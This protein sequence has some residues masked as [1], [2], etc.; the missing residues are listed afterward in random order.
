VTGWIREY[1]GYEPADERLRESLCTLGN[2]YFATRG[3][4]PEC[5]ADGVHYPGTYVA[6]CYNRLTSDVAGHQV[7]NEDMVNAPNWLP[8]NF[9]LPG[10]PW[11][12]PDTATVLEHHMSLHLAAGMSERRTR[13]DLGEGQALTVRQ[14]R[15]V[16]MADPHLAASRTEFTAEGSTGGL[17]VE[18]AL[19]GG[20]TNSG[21]ERYRDLDGRHLTHVRTGTA[22]PDTVWLRCRTRTSDIRIG[23]AARLHAGTDITVRADVPRVAQL[24]RLK[25][26]APQQSGHCHHD[27]PIGPGAGGALRT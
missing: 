4:L 14:Q 21:V 24:L 11:L 15:L 1:D 17:D 8:L 6:G 26:A 25:L 2:G 27:V 12:T 18:A 3:A 20:V 13:Y 19:D 10:G 16:H 22:A 23:M 9:R 5:V 7:E